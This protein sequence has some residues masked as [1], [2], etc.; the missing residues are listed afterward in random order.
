MSVGAQHQNEGKP[1]QGTRAKIRVRQQHIKA[2]LLT[3]VDTSK[4]PAAADSAEE[5]HWHAGG[6]ARRRRRPPGWHAGPE[7]G[8]E[9]AR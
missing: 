3:P 1:A 6:R 5:P 7:R 2:P 9:R 4:L 8:P